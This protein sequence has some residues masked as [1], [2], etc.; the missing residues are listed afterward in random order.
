MQT[1]DWD[2]RLGFLAQDGQ[3]YTTVRDMFFQIPV[4]ETKFL[5]PDIYI[6][7]PPLDFMASMG[8]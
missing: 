6:D 2:T 8:V 5:Y 3:L 1:V 4:K 7:P